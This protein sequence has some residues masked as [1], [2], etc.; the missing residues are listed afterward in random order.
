ML[1]RRTWALDVL[2]LLVLVKLTF[3]SKPFWCIRKEIVMTENCEYDIFGNKYNLITAL[4][5]MNQDTFFFSF[6]ILAYFNIKQ[7]MVFMFMRQAKTSATFDRKLRLSLTTLINVLHV[8]FYFLSKE[9]VVV[10]DGCS[11]MRMA[12]LLVQV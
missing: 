2:L 8:F 7:Y 4:M 11:L 12:F 5:T 3:F 6:A 1:E 10:F 9:N